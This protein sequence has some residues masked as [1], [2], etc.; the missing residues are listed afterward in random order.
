MALLQTAH[1]QTPDWEAT[2]MSDLP[3]NSAVVQVETVR[4]ALDYD[5]ATGGFTWRWRSDMRA[6]WNTRWAGKP[7]GSIWKREGYSS[8]IQIGLYGRSYWAHR[9]AWLYV[10]GEWPPFRL[11]HRDGNGLN[12]AIGNLRPATT[13]QNRANSRTGRNNIIGLKGVYLTK[14]GKFR[15]AIR[16]SGRQRTIGYFDTAEEAHAAYAREATREFGAYAHDGMVG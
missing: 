13:G 2:A 9:L 16:A 5:P 12:N 10:N 1:R 3:R 6:G 4:A 14:T 7:A 8:Y 11:D 15:A